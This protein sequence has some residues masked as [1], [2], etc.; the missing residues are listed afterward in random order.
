MKFT[1]ERF[2]TEVHGNIELEHLHRYLLACKIAT[3]KVVLDIASGEG[4]GS[5]MLAQTALKVTGV[6]IS[7]EAISHAQ[8]K[9]QASNLEFRLGSCS[10]IPLDNASVDVVIS[11][12]TIEHHDEH[13]TMMQEIKRVLRPDGVLVISSPDKREFSAKFG[14]TNVYH[15][16]E[17]YRD[18]F[19]KLLDSHFKN[20]SMYGQRVVY[21]SAIFREDGLSPV[22]SYE[23]D[24]EGLPAIPGVPHAIYLV[25]IATDAALPLLSSGVLEQRIEDTD[26]TKFWQNL[27]AERDN[28]IASLD[29]ALTDRAAQIDALDQTVLERDQALAGRDA[30]LQDLNQTLTERAAQIAVLDQTVIERNHALAG[31]DAQIG[32]LNQA[33]AE[34]DGRIGILE[35]QLSDVQALLNSVLVSSSW[36]ITEPLRWFRRNLITL[37]SRLFRNKLSSTSHNVTHRDPEPNP[38]GHIGPCLMQAEQPLILN[39]LNKLPDEFDQAVYL[40]LNPDLMKA[41]VDPIAHY[42]HHG[43]HEK[44]LFSLPFTLRYGGQNVDSTR[45]T[46]LIVTHEASRTGAPVLSLNLAQT[47]AQRYNLVAL[48]LAGGPLDEAFLRVCATVIKVTGTHLHPPAAELLIGQLCKQFD[49]KFALINSIESRV[50]LAPLSKHFIPTISLIHEFAAYTRPADAFRTAM[51]WSSEIIFSASITQE[52]AMTAHPDLTAFCSHIL[53]Q[54]RCILP[55]EEFDVAKLETEKNR[56][57]RLMRPETASNDSLVILGAGFVQLRKGVELFIECAARVIQTPEGQRC[58]FIWIGRGYDPENDITYSAY[59]ADQIHRAGL[60]KHVFFIDETH[61]I[62]TAYEEADLFLLSSRLDPLPNVAIDAM[63]HGVPVLCF[64]K[65]TGIADFLIDSG[66]SEHCVAEYLDSAEMAKK[67]L[68]LVKSEELREQ[69]GECCREA[70][71]RYFEIN[72]YVSNLEKLALDA[73]RRTQ[74]EKA[75]TRTIIHSGR[76]RRDFAPSPYKYRESIET[77]VRDYVR[78]WASGIGRRKPF[79]GFHPGIYL[80]QHGLAIQGADPFAD[81]LR[82]GQP[83]G[84]W[85]YPV[86]TGGSSCEKDL[87]ENQKI[88]LHLHVYYPELLPEITARLSRNRICPDLFI[89]ITN[90]EDRASVVEEL[91]DYEGSIVDIQLVPNRGRDIGPLLTAFGHRIIDNYDFIGHLHTKKTADIKDENT[92]KSWYRFLLENLLGGESKAFADRILFEMKKDTTIGMVFPDDPNIVGWSANQPYAIPLAQQIGLQQLPEHFI[93]PIGTMF[94]ARTSA[95]APWINLNL[96]WD[97]YPEEPLP[98]DGSPLHALERLLPLTL[99]LTGLHTAATHVAGVTR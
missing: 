8:A 73:C 42:L 28:Q 78:A 88:A 71:V 90:Q 50:V 62:E 36:K 52:N 15:V 23:L 47:L 14:S 17:L 72:K 58:R 10:A 11:F 91:K 4:Y 40:A 19:A 87:P 84:P 49:F 35:R 82:T 69:I 57:R 26:F 37:S 86:I 9:Y 59:L 46:I 65:T 60:E 98:Y 75:D 53:P 56:I 21:G 83:D 31:R 54:G 39:S 29:Q 38:S 61:T 63:A 67:I 33:V 64:N 45:E 93:F 32:G 85:N 81:Y 34:R 13:E 51:F 89:S 6:D 7:Q 3:G 79:P 24:S 66:L 22:K 44:R 27:T 55:V 99:S 76:F 30:Q 48:C 20:F 92:G 5:K 74:Q 16:K 95:L 68:T 12:E 80:E 41:K 70:S 43:C 97:D 96:N 94:W 25:A 77:E 18:E 1:G 2:T